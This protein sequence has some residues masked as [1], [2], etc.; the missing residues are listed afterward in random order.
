MGEGG[1]EGGERSDLI[2]AAATKRSVG[3]ADAAFRGH[4]NGCDMWG[5]GWSGELLVNR[6]F[7]R[8]DGT[9][10]ERAVFDIRMVATTRIAALCH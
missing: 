6:L 4:L 3:S 7:L 5:G 2:Y 8:R 10:S 1:R 9:R